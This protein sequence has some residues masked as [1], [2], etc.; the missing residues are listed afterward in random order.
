M[1]VPVTAYKKRPAWKWETLLNPVRGTPGS[2][3]RI[4]KLCNNR[5]SADSVVRA[6]KA[7]MREARPYERWKF[8]ARSMQDISGEYGVFATYLGVMSE[9]EYQEKQIKSAA[10]SARMKKIHAEK[11]VMKSL[12]SVTDIRQITRPVQGRG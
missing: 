3:A 2:S 6:I 5:Q 4:H 12:G 10:W 7:R 1:P 9:Q 11:K 8:E